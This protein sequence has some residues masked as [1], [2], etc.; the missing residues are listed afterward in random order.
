MGEQRYLP[1]KVE[2]G[3]FQPKGHGYEEAV[4]KRLERLRRKNEE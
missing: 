1:E 4:I 2:G 3:W